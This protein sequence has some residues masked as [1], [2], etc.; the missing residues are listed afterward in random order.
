MIATYRDI[1]NRLPDATRLDQYQ[2]DV[3]RLDQFAPVKAALGGR[4]IDLLVANAAIAHDPMRL[5]ALDFEFGRRILDT[6]TLGPL[7]LVET[8]L[9]NVKASEQRKILFV[10]S[11]M[12]SIASNLSGGHYVYR[13][14]KAG[15]NAIARSLAIDLFQHGIIVVMLHPG[16]VQTSGGNPKSPLT[17]APLLRFVLVSFLTHLANRGPSS[18]ADPQLRCV[19]EVGDGGAAWSAFQVRARLDVVQTSAAHALHV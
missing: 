2:L 12:G 8:L 4:P 11:R 19:A 7:R 14:S 10:T 13:A 9:D 3:T 15:L 6:N 18:Q 17:V 5:G 1:A 16:G